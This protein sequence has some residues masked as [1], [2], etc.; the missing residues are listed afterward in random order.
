MATTTTTTT[1]TGGVDI[2]RWFEQQTLQ[3]STRWFVA[4]SS[5]KT[6]DA[7]QVLIDEKV[8]INQS[9]HVMSCDVGWPIGE[10]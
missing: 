2:L 7:V 8:S 4:S 6:S 9:C 5:T 10:C 3:I 1:T